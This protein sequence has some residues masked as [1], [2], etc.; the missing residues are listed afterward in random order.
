MKEYIYLIL[1][2]LIVNFC[3]AEDII[4]LNPYKQNT[5]IDIK[6]QCQNSG[7]LCSNSALCNITVTYPSPNIDYM[8]FDQPM[9]QNRSFYNYTLSDSSNLGWHTMSISCVD[10]TDKVTNNYK[11][12]ITETG[13]ESSTFF[14]YKIELMMKIAFFVFL[15]VLCIWGIRAVKKAEKTPY[16]LVALLRSLWAGS[17][18]AM[19]FISPL[20][21]LFLFHPNFEIGIVQR[22]TLNTYLVL[23]AIA[24]PVILFNIFYFGSQFLMKLG[25]L[26]YDAERTNQV[27]N[28]LDKFTG[29][30]SNWKNKL[31]NKI[32]R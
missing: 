28:D 26:Y 17:S 14:I 21:A 2:L 19:I 7:G 29:R 11:F 22:L 20:I 13:D 24:S 6:A 5:Q 32:F 25:G 23:L 1:I 27:L 10:G 15:I 18:Y 16:R 8:V 12:Q 3:L 31:S 9:T 4:E 30:L